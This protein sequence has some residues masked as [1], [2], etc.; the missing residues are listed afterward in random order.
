MC[1]S[2]VVYNANHFL[3]KNRDRLSAN[4]LVLLQKSDNNFIRDL[5]LAVLDDTGVLSRSRPLQS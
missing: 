2:Q 1:L 3:E 5:F 4:L